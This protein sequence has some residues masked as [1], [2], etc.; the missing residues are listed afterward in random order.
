M[1]PVVGY[2]SSLWSESELGYERASLLKDQKEG[3]MR[4]CTEE[5]AMLTLR[6]DQLLPLCE[7]STN[8]GSTHSQLQLL[9]PLFWLSPAPWEP[10]G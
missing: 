2:N 7:K 1:K 5:V 6:S 9:T 4:N 8:S 10:S 3:L